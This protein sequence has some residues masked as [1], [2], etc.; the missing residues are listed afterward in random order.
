MKRSREL[1]ED[2]ETSY[3]GV[4]TGRA[5]SRDTVLPPAKFPHIDSAVEEGDGNEVTTMRCSFPPHKEPLFFQSYQEYECHYNMF[6]TNRCL[7]CRKNFPSEHLLGVHIEECHDPLVKVRR[8]KGEHTYSCFVEGCERKCLTHQ[9]RRLHMID[10]HMYPKNFFFGV[11][12]E[13]IDGKRSL[14]VETGHR[15]RTSSAASSFK[16]TRRR[17]S[18]GEARDAG[19][20]GESK[21]CTA[22]CFASVDRKLPQ[23]EN[24]DANMEDLTGA[25]SA[26]QFVPPIVKF[27]RGRAGF[28][29]S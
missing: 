13:G 1:G 26:L 29:K 24:T 19:P 25:M 9:K 17:L 3:Q 22:P 5:A 21:N 20:H 16:E 27:G 18:I 12:K 28:S 23:G 4:G 10:K 14:L 15:R 2:L 8:E 11:T 7:G 6:H